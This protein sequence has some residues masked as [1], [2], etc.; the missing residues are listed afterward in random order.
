MRAD[1]RKNRA[2]ILA[3][4]RRMSRDGDV[5]PSF[6][7]LAKHAGIGVGTV[8]RH[9]ADHRALLA[10]LVED[11]IVQLEAVLARA[12]AHGDPFE[13][14][15]VLFRGAL[16][17]ELE[18]PAIAK[19]LS[20]PGA[21]SQELGQRLAALEHDAG[22]VVTRAQKAKVIRGDLKPGDFRRLVCGLELAVRAGDAPQEAAE[23]Y[24]AIVLDG[25]RPSARPRAR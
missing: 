22:Y 18:C 13:A 9:F 12:R 10:G 23:R 1:A 17:L 2:H 7:D 21:P 5:A 24:V 14:L 19:L 4:A 11:Q 25:L 3:V 15:A 8:Y 16:A 6:N 20:T